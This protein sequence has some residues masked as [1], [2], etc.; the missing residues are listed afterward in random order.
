MSLSVTLLKY[1]FIRAWERDAG[2]IKREVLRYN[3]P[4]T[5]PVYVLQERKS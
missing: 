3:T 2:Y 5:R 4:F 1:G